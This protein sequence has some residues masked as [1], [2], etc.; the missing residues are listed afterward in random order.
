MFKLQGLTIKVDHMAK[1]LSRK[2]QGLQVNSLHNRDQPLQVRGSELK[3]CGRRSEH[4]FTVNIN[5]VL[6]VSSEP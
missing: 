3:L 4:I 6:V 5:K 1:V 2:V